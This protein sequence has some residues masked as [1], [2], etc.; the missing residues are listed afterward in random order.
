MPYTLRDNLKK[1]NRHV[2]K[3]NIFEPGPPASVLQHRRQH[4]RKTSRRRLA[5]KVRPQ[6]ETVTA[7]TPPRWLHP[8]LHCAVRQ[9]PQTAAKVKF[10]CVNYENIEQET[11]SF[12]RCTDKVL[13][14]RRQERV[15]SATRQPRVG[16]STLP[17][18]LLD[19]PPPGSIRK[20]HRPI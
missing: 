1:I 18:R 19:A 20:R 8:R 13:P 3:Q 11:K 7:G 16:Y 9:P 6:G 17:S 10:I 14:C 5:A 4:R 12:P 15:E 2:C